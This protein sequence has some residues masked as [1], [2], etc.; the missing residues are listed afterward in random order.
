MSIILHMGVHLITGA[1]I[2][3]LTLDKWLSSLKTYII[4]GMLGALI[5]ITPDITKFFGDVYLH[6][7]I[8]VPFVGAAFA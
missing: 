2:L 1:A 6:S 3:L 5:S 7:L 4:A 8:T